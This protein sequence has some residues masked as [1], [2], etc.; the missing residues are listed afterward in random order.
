[1]SMFPP[2]SDESK[3]WMFNDLLDIEELASVSSVEEANKLLQQ[4]W[5]LI[6]FH[7]APPVPH[8]PTTIFIMARLWDGDDEDDNDDPVELQGLE[9]LL[10]H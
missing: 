3:D 5:D 7:P 10:H 2:P 4:G 1:M 9:Q 6:G 8:G